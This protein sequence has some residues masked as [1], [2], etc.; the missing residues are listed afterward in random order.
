MA[1]DTHAHV[2]PER[3][4]D[5]LEAAGVP[6]SRTRIARGMGADDSEHDMSLRL[7]MMDAAGVTCQ[8]LSAVPQLPVVDDAAKA[9]ECARM[10]ND[11]YRALLD[12]YPD[13]FV[14]YGALTLPHVD[15]SLEQ[16]GY[17]L[18]DLGFV[19]VGINTFVDV[20]GPVTDDALVPVFEELDRR[21]AIVYLHPSGL[22]A[23]CR[24]ISE[25]GLTWVN[26]APM[27]DAIATLHL[28]KADYPN[29]FPHIRFH[30]AHLG[31]DIPFLAQRIEDN[32]ESWNAFARSP[33][34]SLQRMWFDAANFFAP[35]LRLAL[36]VFDPGKVLAG[37]DFPY[38]QDDKYTRAIE[39]IRTSGLDPAVV[40]DILTGNAATLYG[41]ALP[42]GAVPPGSA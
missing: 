30:I 33:R 28:L 7:G 24:P 34:E 23:G 37:S 6:A 2:Y 15:A 20:E 22:S 26:G 4:L 3:Y 12:R 16:I 32:Y 27:E 39:Y 38:F 5:A 11:L 21:G 25:H 40:A 36:E 19:G 42:P 35:S 18:D 8:V 9:G 14:A 1:I 31:G 10:V 13:R 41:D 17:C 29:R